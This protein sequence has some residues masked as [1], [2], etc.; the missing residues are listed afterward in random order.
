MSD[1]QT[2]LI[3][4][5]SGFL[6][7]HL[8]LGLRDDFRVISTFRTNPIPISGVLSLPVD[9]NS[10]EW[11]KEVLKKFRP[12]TIVYIAGGQEE[13]WIEK[14]HAAAE[15]VHSNGPGVILKFSDFFAPRMI[16]IS[17]C[18]V[19]DG[20]K[21]NYKETDSLSP[22]N[23]LGKLKAG[24]ENLVR[25]R[26]SSWTILRTSPLY[27]L[28][29][30]WR[31]SFIDRLRS[32]LSRSEKVELQNYELHSFAPVTGMTEVLRGIIREGTKQSIFHYGGLT[33]LTHYEFGLL[34]AKAHGFDE[35]LISP[36][37]KPHEKSHLVSDQNRLDFSLNS[38]EIMKMIPSVKS[39]EAED[40]VRLIRPVT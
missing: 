21:G 14:N 4:G 23:E 16:Y 2:C 25:G 33:R 37:N 26:A 28:S 40:G 15:K 12:E 29:H 11:L 36:K 22:Y 8:A 3:F 34:F 5:G 18:Y 10:E 24:G 9:L 39:C 35:N 17:S 27:G 30:P 38:T 6:G 20:S 31:P 32:S 1:S 19:F 7:T 13:A